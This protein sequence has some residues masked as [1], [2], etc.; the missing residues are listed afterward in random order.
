MTGSRAL[1][2]RRLRGP[3]LCECVAGSLHRNQK[4]RLLSVD[5]H[6]LAKRKSARKWPESGT[7][8]LD[9]ALPLK[10]SCLRKN[11]ALMEHCS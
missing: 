9:Q 7:I 5:E 10:F 6:P 8:D 3:G 2:Q 4:G 11:M 1:Q